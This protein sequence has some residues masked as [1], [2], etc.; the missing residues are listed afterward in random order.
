MVSSNEE[1]IIVFNG[2]I[3]NFLE[4]K[5]ILISKGYKFIS[6]SDTEVLLYSYQE[7]KEKL[8]DKLEDV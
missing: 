6:T 2:E 5:K 7:W 4:I 1:F 8:L 3:Y